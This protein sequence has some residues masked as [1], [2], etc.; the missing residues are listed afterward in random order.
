ML[1]KVLSCC[2]S[3]IDAYLVDVEV[4]ISGGLPSFSIV[5]LPDTAIRES[6]DRIKAAIKNSGFG[7]PAKRITVNLAP[8]NIKKEG[9]GFDL[10]I[11]IGVLVSNGI[12]TQEELKDYVI[13]GEL[14]LDGR[15][16]HIKGVLPITLKLKQL[17][18]ES[19]ILPK[20]NS[21]ESSV[22]KD[23]MVYAA[24][25]LGE[26]VGFL[27]GQLELKPLKSKLK[28]LYRKNSHYNVDFGDVKGQFHVKRGLEVAAA[29]GHNA[30]LIGPPGSGKSM[31]SKRLPTILSDMTIDEA[32][33]TSKVQS[34]AG[35]LSPKRGLTA[36]RPFRSP[37][38]TIS[39][40]AMIGGGSHPRPGEIS[41]VHNG[42]LFLDE[43]P[44]FNRN[45]LEVLRQPLEE[46]E[47][48]VSR[49]EATVT[50]PSRFMLIAAMNPCPCGYFTD[51]KNECFC[52]PHQIQRYLS[53]IS[54]PLLD[55]IDIH[56]QVPRLTYNQ[57]SRKRDSEPSSAIKARVDNARRLQ[58]V[59]Y[60]KEK[61]KFNA[62]LESKAL[63]RFC[64]LDKEGEELLK[65][66]I[67][68]IGISARAYDKILK[69]SR[70]IA[71]LDGKE[72][73]E[74]AHISEAIGYRSL[75]RNLWA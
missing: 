38:H 21:Q 19:I 60:C 34:V 62:Y 46:G 71:D 55:R 57:L 22:T 37:H 72:N 20:D 43:L 69:I 67:L 8:A 1:A 11:A 73:I 54:G 23:V 10:P 25:S 75:D 70:T 74:A 58:E 29:G 42:V 26:V 2:T 4:D 13:C 66:A 30:L 32:L 35:L 7:F 41:L 12:L 18:K 47:I 44:E 27:K 65:A 48:T 3:G 6:R 14:S 61:I 9:A 24:S 52:T 53:K 63:D 36:T 15:I 45:V 40:A 16:K 28:S 17:N 50:Y 31:L 33:E 49:V 51:P 56:L 68:E 64:A 59:R 5:G 39:G